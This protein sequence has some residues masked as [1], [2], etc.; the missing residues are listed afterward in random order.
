LAN[1][2]AAG[3]S[4]VSYKPFLFSSI[5]K[6]PCIVAY[7]G[8]ATNAICVGE[9]VDID[10]VGAVVAIAAAVAIAM[11]FVGE[12]VSMTMEGADVDI[13]RMDGETLG[14]A[15]GAVV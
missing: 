10:A 5:H 6:K 15:T 8:N 7:S 3:G 4:V 11:E 13:E 2:P 1:V 14:V 9:A 12:S